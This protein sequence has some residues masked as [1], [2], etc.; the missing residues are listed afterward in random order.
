MSGFGSVTQN[1]IPVAFIKI[2]GYRTLLI[3]DNTIHHYIAWAT[4][5]S[6]PLPLHINSSVDPIRSKL[7]IK[8]VKL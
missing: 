7:I 4:M 2:T 8:S 1:K 5:W 3:E 6:L